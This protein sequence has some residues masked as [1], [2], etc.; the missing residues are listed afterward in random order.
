M[1]NMS[2]SEEWSLL[3]EIKFSFFKFLWLH[4]ILVVAKELLASAWGI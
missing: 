2:F 3:P 4:F 1:N